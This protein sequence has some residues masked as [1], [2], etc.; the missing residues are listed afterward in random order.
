MSGHVRR[1]L[2]PE[3]ALCMRPPL[4]QEAAKLWCLCRLPY[5][6][7]RPMLA[8]DYCQQ[9]F[10]YDCCGLRP[11]GDDEDD[12][13]VAPPDFKCPACCL[14]VPFLPLADAGLQQERWV[15]GGLFRVCT[16]S[17]RFPLGLIASLEGLHA[18]H[19][20]ACAPALPSADG[21]FQGSVAM[22]AAI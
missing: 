15:F 11:P 19:E 14:K 22:C 6:E 9:W 18:R 5:N 3:Q 17:S 12:D 21:A 20:S 1:P 2:Q 16:T 7:E 4:L 10:H 13:S 8:C